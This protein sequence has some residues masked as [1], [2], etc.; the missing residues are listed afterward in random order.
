M[1]LRLSRALGAA[2]VTLVF[3]SVVAAAPQQ[4]YFISDGVKLHYVTEGQGEPLILVHGFSASA[5]ANWILP[6]VFN[7]LA[8]HYHVIALDNRGHGASGKPHEIA[9]YGT[10]MVDDVIRL[11]DHLHIQKAHIVGYSMGGF[12]TAKLVTTHPERVISAVLGG[13]GWS[14]TEDDHT[15]LE[16]TAK[17]LEEGNG[18]APLMKALTPSGVTPPSDQQL[19]ARNQLLMAANDPKALACCMRG[20]LNLTVPR[21]A[22]VNNKV[23]T[24]AIVGEKD[25]L[26]RSVDP[27]EG[28]MSNL[29]IVV[30]PGGDHISTFRSSQFVDAVTDFLAAHS[31]Q[32][33]TAAAAH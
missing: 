26:K 9:K 2:F 30:V 12:I 13:A 1:K 33:A 21:E 15:V 17:S 24:L 19:K 29:K 25:P 23:P 11:M 3:A 5:Y 7:K 16:A 8:Q 6:G 22:L 31:A 14:R 27:L 10:E 20:M 32:H 28:V 18:I 4:G